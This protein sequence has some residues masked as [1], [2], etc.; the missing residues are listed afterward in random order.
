MTLLIHLSFNKNDFIQYIEQNNINIESYYEL[1]KHELRDILNKKI[2][3]ECYLHFRKKTCCLNIVLKNEILLKCKKINSLINGG[4]NYKN[5]FYNTIDDV[6]NDAIHISEFA[7]LSSVRKTINRINPFLVHSITP[8]I[9]ELKKKEL[10]DR[11]Q[12]KRQANPQLQVK[13]GSVLVYF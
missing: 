13:H 3:T 2:T 9:S 7:D 12:I 8:I 6:I 4:F 10:H 11:E 1:S 5:S